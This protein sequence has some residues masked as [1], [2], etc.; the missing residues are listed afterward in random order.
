MSPTLVRVHRYVALGLGLLVVAIGLTGAALVFRDELT[1]FVTPA[2]KVSSAPVAPG[3]FARILAAA[4]T[5][6]PAARSLDIAPAERIDR[7]AE[8]IIHGDRGERYLLVDPHDGAV[9]A[10]G[11]RQWLPFST[12]YELHRR[13]LSGVAGEYA[14]GFAGFALV[15]LAVSGLVMWWPRKWKQAFRIRWDGNRL[16]VSY[17]LHKCAGAGFALILVTNAVIGIAMTFDEAS[18]AL[19]NRVAGRASP[20]IPAA[21]ANAMDSPSS[22]D[23]IVAAANTAFPEGRVSRIAINSGNTPVMVRKR[24]ATDNDTHGMNR[25]WVDAGSATVLRV[26]PVR[27]QAPGNAMFEWL[28]PLHTGKLVG[29]PYR[30]LLVFAGCVPLLS[31]VTGLIVWRSRAA[32]R[33]PR[34][35]TSS[36]TP[37]H[38][39]G[40]S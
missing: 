36:A 1:S 33:A 4:R 21:S 39:R 16:A 6:E 27:D 5:A 34:P 19:V 9:V 37:R 28:Y 23:D 29:L 18:V 11:D 38:S 26:S 40:T 7:A 24:L 17:D 22:L 13:F 20:S 14:V 10:D 32:R 35:A 2:V 31:L 12:L 25:I 3:E 15:F 8:V 30:L